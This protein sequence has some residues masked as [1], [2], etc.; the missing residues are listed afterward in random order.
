MPQANVKHWRRL[1]NAAKLFPAASSKRDT[2]VFRFYCELKEDIQQEILQKAVDRTL[3]KYPIFLS[4]L[5]KGLFW[6]YLEQSN[7]R[8]V[9][10]EEYKEPCSSLY[11]RDKRDLLFEVTYYKKRINFEV[12]HVLTD[13]TGASE[14]VRELVKNYLYLAHHED[15]LEDVVL[16]EYSESLSDQEADGFE[17]YYSRQA[18]RKKEKKPAAHQLRGNRRELGSLQTTEAEIPVEELKR[19]AKTY[20]VSM[21]VFLTAVYLCAIHRTMTRRQESKPVVLMVP[22]NLRNFFPTNTM[23]NFFNWIEPGYHF[24][25]ILLACVV[26]GGGIYFVRQNLSGGKNTT[27]KVGDTITITPQKLDKTQLKA[28]IDNTE[29]I[30]TET[31]TDESVNELK[32]AVE[33]GNTLLRGVP[34]QDAIEETYMEIVN[35][36]QGLTKK[37]AVGK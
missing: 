20:G 14:F 21:T 15:G 5:R 4:V 7:K 33:K 9:V 3:E 19:Q 1:D 26:I 10:R 25:G 30:N 8:P 34:G 6:H 12:F 18:D 23:L 35:A 29:S 28:L 13:G 32:A 36:I 24:Q 2:R 37:G 27:Q 31:Y 22:V 11:I 16:S 17:R